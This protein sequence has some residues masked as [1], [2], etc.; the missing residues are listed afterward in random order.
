MAN[1][2]AVKSGNWSDVTV[3]NTGAL[4]TSADDVFANA[5]TV[6]IDQDVTV[7]SIRTT[8]QAPAVAGGG[9]TCGSG[10][11]INATVSGIVAGSTNVITFNHTTGSSTINAIVNGSLTAGGTQAIILSSTGTLNIV[12]EVRGFATSFVNATAIAV[13]AAGILNITGNV[14]T[15]GTQKNTIALSTGA[16][17]TVTGNLIGEFNS[18]NSGVCISA[19]SATVNVTGDIYISNSN[20]SSNTGWYCI[21]AAGNSTVNTIGSITNDITVNAIISGS[22]PVIIGGTTYYKHIGSMTAGLRNPA[23]SSASTTAINIFTGPFICHSSGILPF[24]VARM[25]YFRTMGSYFEFRDNS[26][27]GAIPPAAAAPATRLVSPDT[28]VDAPS[29]NNVRFGV[30]YA[31]GSQTGTMRIPPVSS[32]KINIP[33]DNTVGTGVVSADQIWDVLMSGMNTAGSIGER[34]KNVSTVAT[35]GQQISS[36]NS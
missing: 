20:N 22:F 28:V 26:T 33:V 31:S 35:T 8:A 12:G 27:G 11:T 19:T 7:L 13:T 14:V 23:V 9:F 17:L 32:V 4:P 36:Y 24:I 10:R 15:R 5:F 21:S 2:Y 3:W 1:V 34:L 30:V 29:P 18:A 25:H 6:V 16:T